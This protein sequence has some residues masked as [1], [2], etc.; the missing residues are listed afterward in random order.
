[1]KKVTCI[2]RIDGTICGY[3]KSHN[4]MTGHHRRVHQDFPRK[5]SPWSD[6]RLSGGKETVSDFT[7]TDYQLGF[8]LNPC[9]IVN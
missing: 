6:R 4:H 8:P 3:K 7:I 5:P 9:H 2:D 1:M